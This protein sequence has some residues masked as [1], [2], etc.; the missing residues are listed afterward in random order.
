M[1]RYTFTIK[2]LICLV[3]VLAIARVV[4]LN[5]ISTSGV[6]LGRI[7]DKIAGY[8]LENSLLSEK[9]YSISSFAVIASEAAKLGF[10]QSAQNIVLTNSLPI[11]AKQ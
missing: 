4:V 11:A 7:N 3:L 5:L 2:T 1:K 8:K 9:L 10:T 6:E